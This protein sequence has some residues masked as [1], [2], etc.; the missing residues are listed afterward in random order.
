MLHGEFEAW[1]DRDVL[2]SRLVRRIES[3]GIQKVECERR[4]SQLDHTL[5]PVWDLTGLIDKMRQ[6]SEAADLGRWWCKLLKLP[7]RPCGCCFCNGDAVIGWKNKKRHSLLG[8][9][10]LRY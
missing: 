3:K 4:Q 7:I 6:Q 1:A 10:S 8:V 5:G 2:G 9:P